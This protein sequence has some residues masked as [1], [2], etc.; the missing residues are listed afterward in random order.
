MQQTTN[1]AANK[2]TNWGRAL[3]NASFRGRLIIGVAMLAGILMFFPHFF[4]FI[5][6]R[7]GVVL[8]DVLL[9]HIGPVDM[10]IPI[11]IVMWSTTLL[12]ICRCFTNPRIFINALYCLCFL[13]LARMLS[14]YLTPLDPPATIIAI[15]DPLTSLTYG[16]R[17]VFITKDLFFSGHTSNMLMLAL[18]FEKQTD[19]WV[20]YAAAILVGAMV[21]FQ[22]AHYTIDVGAA[23]I[24]TGFIVILGKRAAS[25][26]ACSQLNR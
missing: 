16:G 10:S 23:F 20:G 26:Q 19:R 9:R 3:A 6:A 8:N 14:I 12:F 25:S 24:F 18:C 17:N 4:A 15:K 22:H 13:S 5:E 11:F 2:A 7:K 21:L 1:K